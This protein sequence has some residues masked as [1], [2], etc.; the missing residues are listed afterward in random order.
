MTTE[1]SASSTAASPPVR[2][3][4]SARRKKTVSARLVDGELVVRVPAGLGPEREAELVADMVASFARRFRSDTIDL[5]DRAAVL[6]RRHDLRSPTSI[7]WVSN[8]S[9]R[10]GS[11]TPA[12]GDIRISDRLAGMPTWVLDYVIVHELAHLEIAGH[13]PDFWAIVDRY[14]RTE[15]ARGF[16]MAKALEPDDPD[17]ASD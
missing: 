14:P 9:G 7:R 1:A 10:W 16:L 8:Q 11:C 5:H 12:T 17:P 15:R 4:R 13:G 3:V 6:A 2:V